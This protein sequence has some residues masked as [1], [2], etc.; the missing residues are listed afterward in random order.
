MTAQWALDKA[1]EIAESGEYKCTTERSA[2]VGFMAEKIA[3]ALEEAVAEKD[4]ADLRTKVL[5]ERVAE[6]QAENGHQHD[7]I[8]RLDKE[9]DRLRR[10]AEPGDGQ[11][12]LA[13]EE[14]VAAETERCAKVA[15]SLSVVRPEKPYIPDPEMPDLVIKEGPSHNLV[16]PRKIAAAIRGSDDKQTL[17]E[18]SKE[19]IPH[20]TQRFQ[21]MKEGSDD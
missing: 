16:D 7:E 21:R 20:T 1:R 6:L 5:A 17:L 11:W 18:R 3:Q 15:E 2:Q 19:R 9:I 12:E 8:T 4:G 14:A 13:I 10:D